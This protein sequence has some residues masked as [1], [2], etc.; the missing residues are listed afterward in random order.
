MNM[1]PPC[2][3]CQLQFES[4]N[5]EICNKCPARSDWSDYQAGYITSFNTPPG[6]PIHDKR[7]RYQIIAGLLGYPSEIIMW[8]DLYQN[9][10]LSLV[11]IR[12]KIGTNIYTI[13]KQFRKWEIPIREEKTSQ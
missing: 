13:K 9:Q 2:S 8:K 4:K 12:D 1:N 5:N 10:K 3:Q 6:L 7:D 11:E